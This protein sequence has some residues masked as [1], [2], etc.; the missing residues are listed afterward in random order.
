MISTNPAGTVLGEQLITRAAAVATQPDYSLAGKTVNLGYL[1]GGTAALLN[2]A[3][4]PQLTAP[5]TSDLR[6]AWEQ[7]V[8]KS[9]VHGSDNPLLNLSQVII[10]T[11]DV[12][13]ARTWLEQVKPA[14]PKVPFYVLTSAQSA[15]MISPYVDSGQV[16]GLVAGVLGG[17]LYE[18]NT[19]RPSLAISYWD[20]FQ[21][22]IFLV[23]ILILLG[24][25]VNII[26]HLVKGRRVQKGK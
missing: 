4:S 1:A 19:Q 3:T 20:S 7:P 13:T 25:L 9:L 6:N 14:L 15:P 5:V 11:T 12:D 8:L 22:G 26:D 17:S 23:I 24:G 10:I 21:V 18:E 2:F 16:Q